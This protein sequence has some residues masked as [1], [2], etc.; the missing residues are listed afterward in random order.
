MVPYVGMGERHYHRSPIPIV[1]RASWEFEAVLEGRIA[2]VVDA[3]PWPLRARTL[4]VFPPQVAHGWTGEASAGAEVAV[5]HVPSVPEPLHS[6]AQAQGSI[7]AALTAADAAWLRAGIAELARE[8]TAPTTRGALR[9][10][11]MVS[12]LCLIA[13]RATPEERL[14]GTGR[15]APATVAA[16]VAWYAEHM[17]EDPP[18]T[19]I[20]AAVGISDSQLR[21]LCR[22]VHGLGVHA[23]LQRARY[24]RAQELMRRR[25]LTLEAVATA[26]GFSE[27]SAFS[28]AYRRWHGHPPSRWR[29]RLA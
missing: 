28:R 7:A 18:I 12:E 29:A 5:V 13:L 17:A 15:D 1:S 10:M 11:R 8:Q 20:A 22:Q 26:C 19:R 23:L 25:Q 4:W 27:A 21:R 3:T 24:A 14:T 6:R 16:A 9:V 2:P